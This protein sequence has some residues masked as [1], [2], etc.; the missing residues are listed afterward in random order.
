MMPGKAGPRAPDRHEAPPPGTRGLAGLLA[1]LFRGRGEGAL[2]QLFRYGLVASVAFA[3][4]FGSFY[5]FTRFAGIHYLISA[6]LAFVLGVNTNYFFSVRWV[7]STRAVADRR[8]EAA[9][10]IL[11]GVVGLGLNEVIIWF[12]TE[13]LGFHYLV[14]KI[15]STAMVFFFNFFT[16]KMLLF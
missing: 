11:I 4:D 5:G 2:Y 7:F 6:A 15:C 8:K 3:V 1:R 14:S 10:F 13:V 12:C 9:L 16:R